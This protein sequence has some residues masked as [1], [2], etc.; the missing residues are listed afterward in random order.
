MPIVGVATLGVVDKDKETLPCHRVVSACLCTLRVHV[1]PGEDPLHPYLHAL[2]ERACSLRCQASERISACRPSLKPNVHSAEPSR[3]G[4]AR[5]E[6]HARVRA[7]MR[8][9][10]KGTQPRG[11]GIVF[12]RRRKRC[13][14]LQ[15]F[16]RLAYA[17]A[18]AG[19]LMRVAAGGLRHLG[20]RL[21]Y[22]R[23]CNCLHLSAGL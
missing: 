12:D 19:R 5:W 14:G 7:Q 13:G 22:R 11:G 4:L 15:P 20:P 18:A 8:A 9:A 21:G 10:L 3:Y 16:A 17:E 1:R 6:R 23:C 2:L